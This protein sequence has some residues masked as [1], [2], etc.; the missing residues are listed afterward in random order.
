MMRVIV[1]CS[2]DLEVKRPK[3]RIFSPKFG[4]Y[5]NVPIQGTESGAGKHPDAARANLRACRYVAI[6]TFGLQ[7]THDRL[8]V[9]LL[10]RQHRC[11]NTAR[12]D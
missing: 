9:N 6:K 4:L 5:C 7:E 11:S 12:R 10:P 1:I 3:E 8:A 2:N